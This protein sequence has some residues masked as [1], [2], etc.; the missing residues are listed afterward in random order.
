MQS[1]LVNI[2]LPASLIMIAI[3]AFLAFLFPL[4]SAVT[5]PRGAVKGIAGFAVLGV[6]FIIAYSTASADNPSPYVDVSE[7]TAKLVSAGLTTV[8]ILLLLTIVSV[9]YSF[10]SNL[11]K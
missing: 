7:N 9:V 2:L 4:I 11:L 3:T 5:N 8:G 1:F 10:L 6:I